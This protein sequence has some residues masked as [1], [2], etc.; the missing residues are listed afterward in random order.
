MKHKKEKILLIL[1]ICAFL[2]LIIFSLCQWE[3][4]VYLFK[5][6]VAGVS[7]VKEYVLSLGI[8]GVLAISLLII[9]GFF[10]PIISSIPLQLT[11]AVCYGLPFGIL[12]VLA[13]VVIASQLVFLCN[14]SIR[15]FQSPR[16][17]K[18]RLQMEEKIR[19]SRRKIEVFLL[20][21]YLAPFVPFLIIHTVAADSGMSWKKYS[22]IT[23]IG[24]IPDIV[25]TLWLGQK[26]TTGTS[27]VVSYAT[28][29]FVVICVVLSIIYKDKLIDLIFKPKAEGD[30]IHGE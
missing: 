24:P 13:S 19:T 12:H 9:V 22:L 3:T 4:I 29:L 28:L 20:L 7:V 1:T 6:M 8:V 14:R 15:V 21:A 23:L 17:R 30:N 11:S 18:K 2:A 10:F 16:Q 25:I 27:P 5:Q 26:I